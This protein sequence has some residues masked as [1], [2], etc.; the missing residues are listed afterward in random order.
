MVAVAGH[1]CNSKT[2]LTLML[3]LCH[4]LSEHLRIVKGGPIPG[5]RH[6]E[7]IETSGVDITATNYS[8]Y[9]LRS[10][11]NNCFH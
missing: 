3:L 2:Y 7:L 5:I 8:G 10:H 6:L 9:N 1:V 11:L 4:L